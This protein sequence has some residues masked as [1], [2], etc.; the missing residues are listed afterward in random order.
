MTTTSPRTIIIGLDGATF[1]LIDPLIAAGELP[2]LNRIMTEGVR[3]ILETWPNTNSAAAWSSM[4]TGCNSGQHGIFHFG[5]AITR[6]GAPWR[7]VTAI[8]RKRDAF[9]RILS[10]A[11]QHVGVINMPITYPAD[12]IN[13]FMLA[14]MDTPGLSSP[15]FAHPTAL[16]QDLTRHGID[17]I[18]DVP[19]LG[20]ASRRNPHRL[21]ESV[22][23]MIDARSR[24]ILHLMQ[25][26]RWD[27]LMGVFV[28]TDRVQHYFWPE[29]LSSVGSPDW[30]PIR[31]VYQ[32]IDS[33]LSRLLS[34]VDSN[35][36]LLLV[37]DH[38][39]GTDRGARRGLNRLF[40]KLGLL[41]Y[42]QG[43][44]RIS[45][46]VLRHLLAYGR[47]YIP[48]TLQ[49]RL[50]RAMPGLHLRAVNEHQFSGVDWP[51]TQVF[52][53]PLGG[54]VV[55][56]LEGREQDGTVSPK[57]YE[58]FRE[59]LIAVLLNLT[60]AKTGDRLV[61]AVHRRE[62]IYR[63]PQTAKASDL[64]VEWDDEATRDTLCY[65]A[66]GKR[67]VIDCAPKQGSRNQ[68]NATHRRE[69]IFIARGPHVR[70]GTTV[71][72]ANIYD[73]AATVL[74]LQ[75]H[76]VP[77]DMDGKVLT[78]I[79]SEEFLREN[80]VR[81]YHH[82]TKEGKVAGGIDASEARE[83]EERLRGLGYIE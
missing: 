16:R 17:Y 82:E 21:P 65:E 74:Y 75:N 44:E 28:A 53:G 3:G 56:N 10:A 15:G 6:R 40:E 22:T 24:T 83:I 8:D 48:G 36:T 30:I 4:V 7:P 80:A 72:G 46:R 26:R 45:G 78:D 37:S 25:H 62:E 68:W 49:D 11:G 5:E 60:D 50:A 19:N 18:I 43:G 76:P 20:V 1:D 57:D 54:R 23:R 59:R 38:G 31:R 81:H 12:R 33:F 69:G 70:C 61:R 39:F 34:L 32:Q 51:A 47:R 27:V 71:V 55:I 67:I 42:R 66:E 35:T 41:R 2:A 77:D 79:F 13:G 29:D 14:G 58:A 52:S 73:V 9:W 64:L 63:G